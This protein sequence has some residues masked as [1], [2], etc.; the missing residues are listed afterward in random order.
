M[1]NP[2]IKSLLVASSIL[3]IGV[4]IWQ[5]CSDSSFSPTDSQR[6]GTQPLV[7]KGG[8]PYIRA[9]MRTISRSESNYN[10]PYNVIYG[11]KYVE[12]LTQHPNKCQP[13]LAG[14]N[15]GNCSTAAGRY[16]FINTTWAEKAK[17]YHSHPPGL[18]FWKTYSF[19]PQYQDQVMYNW[20]NDPQS[21]NGKDIK[22]LLRQ[23]ELNQVLCMLSPTWTSLPCGIEINFNTKNLPDTYRKMLA[24]EEQKK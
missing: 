17:R 6:K 9:L 2:K 12:D 23:G 14:P 20:L 8:D 7:M 18:L 5:S 11:G 22:M 4:I 13:I 16:Q 19:E 21:W 1:N 15:K 3:I 10:R 24:D